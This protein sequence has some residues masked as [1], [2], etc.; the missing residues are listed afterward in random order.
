MTISQAPA[1]SSGHRSKSS[2][3][4]NIADRSRMDMCRLQDIFQPSGC[5]HCLRTALNPQYPKLACTGSLQA[6]PAKSLLPI[7][8]YGRKF[9]SRLAGCK[10][11]RD[12]SPALQLS[13]LL[14]VML[15]YDHLPVE[16]LVP[17]ALKL[18]LPRIMRPLN[19]PA[20]AD[21]C[22]GYLWFLSQHLLHDMQVR[23]VVSDRETCSLC[24][25]AVCNSCKF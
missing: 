3:T 24:M 10:K 17:G 18:L 11:L 7:A 15:A 4:S 13:E 8:A 1:D 22:S 19:P 25:S 12:I 5:Q 14:Q 6:E 23:L 21:L 9:L 16:G 20:A 2:C